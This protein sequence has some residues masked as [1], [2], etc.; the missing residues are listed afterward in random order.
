L[1]NWRIEGLKDWK[2]EK[3][4]DWKIERLVGKGEKTHPV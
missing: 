4:E 2:I 3:L 1:E